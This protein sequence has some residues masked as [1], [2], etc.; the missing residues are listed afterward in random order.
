[1]Q[2]FRIDSYSETSYSHGRVLQLAEC[3]I[4]VAMSVCPRVRAKHVRGVA[5]L[6]YVFVQEINIFQILYASLGLTY[7]CDRNCF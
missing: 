7:L 5:R 3:L 4:K 6:C 2:H 1:M